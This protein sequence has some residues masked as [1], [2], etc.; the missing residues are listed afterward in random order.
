VWVHQT[1]YR[2]GPVCTGPSTGNCMVLGIFAKIH[3]IVNN[4][5]FDD[6]L[7]I[8]QQLVCKR[9]VLAQRLADVAQSGGHLSG[10]VTTQDGNQQSRS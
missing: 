3:R 1:L 10:L 2:V 7:D 5:G 9:A 6:A 4:T 8:I